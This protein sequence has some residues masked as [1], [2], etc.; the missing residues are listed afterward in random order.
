MD[1]ISHFLFGFIFFG[2]WNVNIFLI[3]L[4]SNLPDIFALPFMIYY[5]KMEKKAYFLVL[6]NGYRMKII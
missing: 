2:S 6:L 4:F 3:L 5:L 1:L